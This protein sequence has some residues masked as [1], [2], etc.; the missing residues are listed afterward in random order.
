VSP[1]ADRSGTVVSNKR[2]AMRAAMA[3]DFPPR[4]TVESWPA[5]RLDRGEVTKLVT[6]T[7]LIGD[8]DAQTRR[9]RAIGLEL[10]LDWLGAKAG[11]T[12]QQRWCSVEADVASTAWRQVRTTWLDERVHRA[13]WHQDFVSVALRA[14]ISA[15]VLRPS[16][17]WLLSGAMGR[18]A[19]VRMLAVSRDPVG[20]ARLGEHCDQHLEVSARAQTH[21]WYRVG[22]I[23]AAKGGGLAQIT[24]GDVLELL[25]AEADTPRGVADG[26]TVFYRVLHDSGV[27]G[28]EAPSTLRPLRTIGQRT[29]EEMIDR[30]RIACGPV[31]DLL[32]EY[33]KERQPALDYN[34]LDTLANLLGRRFWAD[35]EAHHPGIDSLRLAPGVATAW[36]QRLRTVPKKVRTETGE[37]EEM[38]VE[39]LSY[40]ECLTPV[41]AFYLDLAQWAIEDPQRWGP[42]VAPSP[43]GE[44]EGVRRKFTRQRKSRMDA[45]TRARLPMLPA[46]LRAV[47]QRRN[48][49][50]AL[51]EAGR[52]AGPGQA[53]TVAGSTLVRRARAGGIWVEDPATGTRRDLAIEE[54]HAFWAWAIVEV[55]HRTGIRVEEL[56]ELSHHS[57]VQYRLP[58]TGELVPLL[59][60]VPSKTDKERL[61]LVSPELADVL[62]VIICRNRDERGAVPLVAP[63]DDYEHVWLPPAPRLFQRRI[64]GERRAFAHSTLL[65]ILTAA[66]IQSGLADPVEGRPLHYTPHDFRRMFITDA[67]LNGLPP[68]IAQIIAGHQDI[69]V[70]LGYKAVYPEEAV[71][72]HLAFL[73]RRRSLRP[74]EEYRV[75]TDQ[76]WQEFLGHFERRKV[77]VGTCARAFGTPCVHEHACVRCPMLWPDPDQRPRLVDLRDN[78]AA[79]IAEA[80]HHGWLG[81][82]EG[83]QVSL[84]GAED[85]LAQIDRRSHTD[86]PVEL[87]VKLK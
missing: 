21:T 40:R 74:G 29:P 31:R 48:T 32:V 3:R 84:A 35:L 8:A 49:T 11:A 23:M 10:L 67:I 56:L 65:K 28:P 45:R 83:L 52:R 25:E 57:L 34:T 81:E 44:E 15:D 9:K 79:R 17:G 6:S 7:A 75:P 37:H 1:A 20:F 72:A 33:L 41:R 77:S 36:K 53:F 39:R 12:W 47:D 22:L 71:Q 26:T 78:L 68:H 58:T 42:W 60:I 14:A 13:S 50:A 51:L 4:P 86:T 24:V 46:L 27:L 38:V 69:N 62:S 87:T 73:A 2:S 16:L 76:E 82:V 18:G 61:L 66:V 30:Y 85:K 43:V 63:Y 64:N 19:L 5:T 55:L 59:Q 70:T 54:E 80:E